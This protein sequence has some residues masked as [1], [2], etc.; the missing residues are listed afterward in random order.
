MSKLTGYDYLNGFFK[1]IEEKNVRP[2]AQLLGL[3]LLHLNNRAGNEGSF[4]C[5]DNELK[6]LTNLSKS[7]ITDA[8]QALKALNLL[9]F[10]TDKNAPRSGTLYTLNAEFFS[11]YLAQKRQKVG[12]KVEQRVGQKV[13]QKVGQTSRS[14]TMSSN[15]LSIKEIKKEE[16]KKEENIKIKKTRTRD[17]YNIID[18]IEVDGRVEYFGLPLDPKLQEKWEKNTRNG[19]RKLDGKLTDYEF[20]RLS[21]LQEKYGIEKLGKA[22]DMALG[23]NNAGLNHLETSLEKLSKKGEKKQN[24]TSEYAGYW[25]DDEP[26]DTSEY[27]NG[28]GNDDTA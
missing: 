9:D 6:R 8:K 12:Q 10:V 21:R 22:M 4:Y 17:D 15:N 16:E 27:A 14:S 11:L 19:N 5:S 7:A 1:F 23:Y 3:H 13:G 28:W 2:A 25:G 24:G 18:T 26:N 20:T